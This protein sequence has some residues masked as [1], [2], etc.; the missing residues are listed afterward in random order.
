LKEKEAKCSRNFRTASPRLP[1]WLEN[2]EKKLEAINYV[3]FGKFFYVMQ[4]GDTRSDY[5]SYL[6]TIENFYFITMA[7]RAC[8]KYLLPSF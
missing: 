4:V 1:L 2:K 3:T 7:E 8:A 5:I 6:Y